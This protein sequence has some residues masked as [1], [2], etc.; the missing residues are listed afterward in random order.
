MKADYSKVAAMRAWT[1]AIAACAL[2]LPGCG[3][4]GFRKT[5]SDDELGTA[6][7]VVRVAYKVDT[8]NGAGGFGG[9]ERDVLVKRGGRWYISSWQTLP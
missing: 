2:L 5:P 8:P 9:S 6:R 7:A 4:I 1:T 3:W